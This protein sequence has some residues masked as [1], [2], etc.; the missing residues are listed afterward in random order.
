MDAVTKNIQNKDLA[1]LTT[2]APDHVIKAIHKACASK[3]VNFAYMLQQASAESSFNPTAKARSSSASGLY[4]FIESTWLQMVRKY[5]DECGMGDLAAQIDKN[6]KVAD[7][8]VRKQILALRNDP[9]KAAVMAAAL[10]NENQAVLKKS[11]G[12]DVGSTELYL[13][14]FLGSGKAAGFMKA[15]D[16]NP[17]QPAADLFPQAA[18]ANRSVFYSADGRA[19]TLS[20]VYNHFDKKFA[21][22]DAEIPALPTPQEETTIAAAPSKIFTAEHNYQAL[23][24]MLQEPSRTPIPGYHHLL[25]SPIEL[26]MLSQLD[27]PTFGD[28]SERLF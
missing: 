1:A 19:K 3:G 26:M 6:G 9:E 10:A 20:E 13:A 25:A 27:L 7:R 15:M 14:H 28:K 12:G 4:Q 23:S 18:A 2:R 17:L 22:E 11:W 8:A 16:R 24:R 21:I 5:G